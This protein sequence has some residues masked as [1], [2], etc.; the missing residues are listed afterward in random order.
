MKRGLHSIYS[1]TLPLYLQFI[2]H[3][4]IRYSLGFLL[5]I[6]EELQEKHR[7]VVIQDLLVVQDVIIQI[8][9]R[10]HVNVQ[11]KIVGGC[12]ALN[13][14]ISQYIKGINAIRHIV[15][16][17]ALIDE[18][19][20]RIG[21]DNV[22]IEENGACLLKDELHQSTKLNLLDDE[23]RDNGPLP[24]FQQVGIAVDPI[25]TISER[26][27]STSTTTDERE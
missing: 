4:H 25:I 2:K 8:A 10:E 13:A 11:K 17:L 12:N 6:L 15:L 9:R 3:I 19:S 14:N 5:C 24:A 1:N 23:H 18:W 20:N 21:W 16:V 26:L 7:I 27:S 22:D